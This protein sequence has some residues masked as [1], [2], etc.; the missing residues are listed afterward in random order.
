MED[1]MPVRYCVCFNVT[2]AEL[3]EAGVKSVEEAAERFGCTTNCGACR[4][5]IE[6]MI[7]TGETA[8]PVFEGDAA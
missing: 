1:P 6:A 7:R 5:Y 2:F 3:K 8:F 4:P